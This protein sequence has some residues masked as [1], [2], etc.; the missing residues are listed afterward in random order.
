MKKAR[1]RLQPVLDVREQA[2]KD[3]A[4]RL[5]DAR[6]ALADAEAELARRIAAVDACRQRQAEAE[7]RLLAALQSG[8]AAHTLLAHRTFIA[9][10]KEEE[11]RLQD[12]V[13]QQRAAVQRAE[14]AVE[15]ALEG[16]IEASKEVQ[17]IEKHRENWRLARKAD[18][19]RR[20]NKAN[21]EFGTS[22]HGRQ[23]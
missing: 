7:T 20:E 11:R 21:D 2:K 3:A 12:A 18:E 6:Q 23:T 22:R 10:L 14:A 4:Q 16:L 13:D 5:A 15:A 17:A 19:E 8:S 9:D 1:Y